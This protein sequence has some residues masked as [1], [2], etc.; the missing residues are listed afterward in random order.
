MGKYIKQQKSLLL[1]IKKSKDDKQGLLNKVKMTRKSLEHEWEKTLKGVGFKVPRYMHHTGRRCTVKGCKGK[2]GDTII[3]FGEDLPQETL[4]TAQ[5]ESEKAD[6]YMVLGSSC[7]VT[8]AA[9]MP[10]SVGLKWRKEIRK[11]KGKDPKHNLCIVNIQKTPLHH[12][13][14]LPIHSK[15]DDVM[16]GVMK[17]LELEIPTW[18]LT[19]YL[20]LSVS[21][22][23]DKQRK[24]CISG[25][26][27]DGT[28]F[29]LFRK[30]LLRQ[31]GKRLIR[32]INNKDLQDHEHKYI[33]DA[34]ENGA[35][36]EK[37]NDG[38][39]AELLFVGNY[40]EPKLCLN[41]SEYLDDFAEC[42]GQ[43]VLKMMMNPST[44]EWTVPNKKEQA[45][46]KDVKSLWF[47]SG[48]NDDEA[49][50]DE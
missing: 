22:L 16:I 7:T 35:T 15:I 17:E 49:K 50:E 40:E 47:I 19:R 26:D 21:H 34:W 43:I 48:D 25:C 9:D 1:Q 11:N 37:D 31:N 14:S 36:E 33:V 5:E 27:I 8:P 6:L 45:A 10:E 44:K 38:L 13:C 18:S 24:F 2:L 12:I 20:R 30:V 28:P 32:M 41:L 3:N 4:R 23:N 42:E 29:S 46:D 39:R